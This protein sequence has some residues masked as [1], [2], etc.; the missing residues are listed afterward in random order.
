MK[1]KLNPERAINKK[2]EAC[3]RDLN[4]EIEIKKGTLVMTLTSG[5]YEPTGIIDK[6]LFVLC[7]LIV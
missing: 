4:I 2:F 7:L 6:G 1:Y 3:K 5:A